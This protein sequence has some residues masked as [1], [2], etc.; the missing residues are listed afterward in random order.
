MGAALIV[1]G[2]GR[3]VVDTN[4]L[5]YV[6]KNLPIGEEYKRLLIGHDVHVSFV[7]PAE[8]F[9]WA[10]RGDWGMRRRLE[11]Q[12]LLAELTVL[13][14]SDGMDK[15]RTRWTDSN[16]CSMI[17]GGL[18]LWP[19]YDVGWIA[20]GNRYAVLPSS[21]RDIVRAEDGDLRQQ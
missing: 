9:C 1:I 12:S 2:K 18:K 10:D 4:V 8:L 15:I 3:V 6:M 17:L 14:Y 21:E 13:P 16:C 20:D 19:G 7:T 5:C 11:L